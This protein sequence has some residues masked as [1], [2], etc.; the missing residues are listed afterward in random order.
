MPK[1]LHK[2]YIYAIDYLRCS[3]QKNQDKVHS[4]M[5]LHKPIEEKDWGVKGEESSKSAYYTMGHQ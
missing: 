4:K 1:L 3:K 5:E 2:S